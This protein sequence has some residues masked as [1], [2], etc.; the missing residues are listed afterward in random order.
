MLLRAEEETLRIQREKN[1]RY[2][3]YLSNVVEHLRGTPYEFVDVLDILN[4]FN[5]LK[6]VNHDLKKRQNDLNKEYDERKRNLQELSKAKSDEQL[7][8]QNEIIFLQK[9][10]DDLSLLSSKSYSSSAENTQAQHDLM[11]TAVIGQVR[12]SVKNLLQRFEAFS[13]RAKLSASYRRTSKNEIKTLEGH[14]EDNQSIEADIVRL[15]EYIADYSAIVNE[16]H[17]NEQTMKS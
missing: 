4:R 11:N 12:I 15:A 13:L 6:K 10:L 7:Q 8:C 14:R 17:M 16:W 2:H 5:T 1:S 9:R 3:N